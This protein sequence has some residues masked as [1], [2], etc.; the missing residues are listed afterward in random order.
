MHAREEKIKT[1]PRSCFSGFIEKGK[2]F[3]EESH[4]RSLKEE[5]KRENFMAGFFKE[6]SQ[7]FNNS[8]AFV[9]EPKKSFGA[10]ME[11]KKGQADYKE[12]SKMKL[13]TVDGRHVIPESFLHQKHRRRSL[14]SDW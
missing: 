8:M 3:S 7:G 4:C 12:D 13:E 2:F 5:P 1:E 6:K 10:K 14:S 11:A 9:G